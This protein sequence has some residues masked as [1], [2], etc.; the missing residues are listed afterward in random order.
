MSEN[1]GKD[2]DEYQWLLCSNRCPHELDKLM[3]VQTIAG[4]ALRELNT[5]LHAVC[6]S[7]KISQDCGCSAVPK[8]D[9]TTGDS[10]I[11]TNS[12]V[13]SIIFLL[14]FHQQMFSGKISKNPLNFLVG[15]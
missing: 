6:T 5:Q 9:D 8:Q 1:N 7:W 15:F 13:T 2:R 12:K 3:L 14:R 10:E 4:D 11:K